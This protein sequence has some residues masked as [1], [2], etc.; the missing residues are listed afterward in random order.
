MSPDRYEV[1]VE[2]V[3]EGPM[4]LLVFLIKKHEL[5]I[6]DIPIAAITDQYLAHLEWMRSL[7]IDV[8]GD[9][10]LMASTLTQIKSRMLLPLHDAGDGEEED[11]RM[12]L[13]RPLAEYLRMKAAAESL[14]ERP[15]L[16]DAVFRRRPP[17]EDAALDPA[18]RGV[19]AGLFELVEAFRQLVRHASARAALTFTEERVSIRDR[20]GEIAAF[21]AE[22]RGTAVFSELFPPDA[23]KDE[24]IV[25]FLAILEMA[26]LE[27]I[28][29]VQDAPAGVLRIARQ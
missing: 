25:T 16:D 13:V 15:L 23:G 28:R 2:T 6:H 12:E 19:E 17:A 29:V 7:N 26:R 22:G 20:I 18:E 9:F 4:D 21:L 1:R 24:M 10:L 3:F 11:P 27:L 5:D 8:A 14:A